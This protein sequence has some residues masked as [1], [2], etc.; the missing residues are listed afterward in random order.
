MRVLRAWKQPKRKGFATLQNKSTVPPISACVAHRCQRHEDVRPMNTHT[1][2]L[3]ECGGCVAEDINNLMVLYEDT[4][5]R[6]DRACNAL[7]LLAPSA[8]EAFRPHP[9]IDH[10]D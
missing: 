1:D 10:I 3:T 5:T 4:R 9:V 2:E 7:D 8:G 6:L